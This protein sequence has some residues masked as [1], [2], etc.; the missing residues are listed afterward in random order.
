MVSSI[1]SNNTLSP[2]KALP[3]EILPLIE[4]NTYDVFV[5]FKNVILPLLPLQV[6]HPTPNIPSLTL[7]L[8]WGRFVMFLYDL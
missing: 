4:N 6:P 2:N 7:K 3:S 8:S 5:V 1:F